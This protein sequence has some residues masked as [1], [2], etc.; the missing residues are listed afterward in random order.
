MTSVLRIA[1]ITGLLS[2]VITGA[3]NDIVFK[4]KS[5]R[6]LTRQDLRN[7]TGK[8]N[9]EI[10]SDKPVSQEAMALHEKG[11]TAGQ[12]GD[13]TAALS[14]FERASRLAPDWPYPIYDA[15]FT[16]LL[17]GDS[18]KALERY[19]R[20]N[21]LAPRGFFTTKTAVD[22]LR[23]ERANKLPAGTYLAYLSLEWI[24]DSARKRQAVE[25]LVQKAPQFAP[26]WEIRAKTATNDAQKLEYL[27]RGLAA[28]PD[29][30][31]YGFLRINQALVLA[32]KGER[33]KAI[34]ILGTLALDPASPLDVE[35]L[36]KWTLTTIF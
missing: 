22:A 20:V 13:Y 4:D 11:R 25:A 24:G 14:H 23:R 34:E 31:T 26:L 27:E 29:P 19:E 15:A 21:A 8:F 18:E 10:K 2:V 35:A 12:K 7:A 28:T 6:I 36:A 32:G 30:E 16:H 33:A 17:Q 1:I 9:W 5:G 3:A